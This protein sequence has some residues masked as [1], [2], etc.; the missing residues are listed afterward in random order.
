MKIN[1]IVA[2]SNNNI[3]GNDNDLPWNYKEDLEYFRKITSYTTNIESKNAVIMGYNTWLSIKK[4]LK[5]RINIVITTK[6]IEK[7]D[8]DNDLFFVNSIDSAIDICKDVYDTKKIEN[9]FIIG[10]EKIYTYFLRSSFNTYLD[11]IY[12]TKI[13]RDFT[14]NKYFPNIDNKFYYTQIS[15]SYKNP[16]LEYRVLQYDKGYNHPDNNYV[17]FLKKMLNYNNEY[18]LK[19]EYDIKSYFP[20]ITLLNLKLYDLKIELMKIIGNNNI[21]IK[22]N[23]IVNKINSNEYANNYSKLCL[24]LIND[25][26]FL[27]NYYFIID[28]ND[29][30]SC[31]INQEYSNII[32]SIPKSII[33]GGLIVYIISAITKKERNLLIYSCVNSYILEENKK[34]YTGII[35][36]N[37]KPLPLLEISNIDNIDNID[38]FVLDDFV[39][40]G[41]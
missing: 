9:I 29:K 22:I 19:L 30:I 14:G 38:D 32:T 36:N 6:I 12:I 10:G 15:R 3:I 13:N 18:C 25:N 39:F 17:F 40:L 23:E 26:L 1:I 20:L 37:P 2:Y 5:N 35:W 28:N 21:K 31:I 24:K 8:G 41:V 27:S 34:D 4:K 16:E 7:T 11:K 33:L